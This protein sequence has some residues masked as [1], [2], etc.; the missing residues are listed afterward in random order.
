MLSHSN[1]L[2]DMRSGSAIEAG[3]N[4]VEACIM[5]AAAVFAYPAALRAYFGERDR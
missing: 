3:S 5:L 1:V 4:G 2:Q